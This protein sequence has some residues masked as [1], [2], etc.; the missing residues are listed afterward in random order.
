MP[1]ELPCIQPNRRQFIAAAAAATCAVCTL[2]PAGAA[3]AR[4]PKAPGRVDAGAGG[5]FGRQGL[6]DAWAKTDGFFLVRDGARLYALSATC[7]HKKK[8]LVSNRG[9]IKCPTHGSTFALD[10]RV[11]K[12]PASRP[13]P[14]FAISLDDRGRVIVDGSRQFGPDEADEPDSFVSL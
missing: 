2:C 4:G 11:K 1:T 3:Y 13:L 14:R 10:G 5:D 12:R 9:A 8:Q 7:T 6:Y